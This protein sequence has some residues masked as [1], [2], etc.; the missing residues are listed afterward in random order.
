KEKF[1]MDI[2]MKRGLGSALKI[3]SSDDLLSLP[4]SIV[5]LTVWNNLFYAS[6]NPAQESDQEVM[7]HLNALVEAYK[8]QIE[9]EKKA[10]TTAAQEVISEL[11]LDAE[12]R[13][14]WPEITNLIE[15]KNALKTLNK[16]ATGGNK[17]WISLWIDAFDDAGQLDV[18]KTF[19]NVFKDEI[20][21]EKLNQLYELMNVYFQIRAVMAQA[22]KVAIEK[23]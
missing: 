11:N 2:A 16:K 7:T 9:T 17:K 10:I 19:G 15:L 22:Q 14:M 20:N 4:T 1:A 21:L 13:A 18:R 5:S 12:L 23:R 6:Y 3:F 8:K